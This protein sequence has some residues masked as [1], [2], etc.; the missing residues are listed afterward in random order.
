M[1][2]FAAEGSEEGA[3]D[4]L[5]MGLDWML[6][7]LNGHETEME[8]RKNE[9]VAGGMKPEEADRQ[10]G[11]KRRRRSESTCWR[12]ASAVCSCPAEELD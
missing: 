8:A 12:V 10:V 7:M 5:E 2:N 6:S 3:S 11:L 1:K 4:V 9:L